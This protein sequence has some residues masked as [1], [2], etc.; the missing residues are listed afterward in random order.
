M[1]SDQIIVDKFIA[2][3]PTDAA[4]ILER[5]KIE[6]I[7]AILKQQPAELAAAVLNH[8]ER[9][10]A[11][12]CLELLGAEHSAQLM[13]NLPMEHACL[14]LRKLDKERRRLVLDQISPAIAD[15]IQSILQYP[16]NSAGAMM[17]PLIFTLPVDITVAEALKRVLKHPEKT[18][19]YLYIVNRKHALVGVINM[20]ELM[21]A[22]G[23]SQLSA[24][25]HRDVVCLSP[26][27]PIQAVIEH[28][29]WSEFH[30]LPVAD[31]SGLLLGVIKY[32]TLHRIGVE[33]R[34]REFSRQSAMA[35]NALGELYRIGLFG[36]FRSAAKDDHKSKS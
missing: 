34:K 7:V 36:L 25:M 11:V 13:E 28:P 16:Q 33:S 10:V 18:L 19:Y 27:T 14:L 2:N 21:V 15:P 35:G 26:E 23:E 30:A 9:L 20:R 4:R 17:D 31:V 12:R 22:S 8:L 24:V 3:H 6:Q 29:D 32:D 5:M 1:Q